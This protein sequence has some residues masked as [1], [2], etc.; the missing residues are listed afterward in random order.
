MTTF[1]FTYPVNSVKLEA[2]PNSDSRT[3]DLV[4]EQ[5]DTIQVE[6]NA[7]QCGSTIG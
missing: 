4:I 5:A 6:N 1:I 3:A 2:G 7:K